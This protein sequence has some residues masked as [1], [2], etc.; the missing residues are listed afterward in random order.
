MKKLNAKTVILWILAMILCITTCAPA[1]A[2]TGDRVLLRM[3]NNEQGWSEDS[4]RMVWNSP[5]GICVMTGWDMKVMRFKDSESEP[6]TF[7][8]KWPEYSGEVVI[9]GLEGLEGLEGIEGLEGLAGIQGI[10]GLEGIEGAEGIQGPET[11]GAEG[12]DA[13]A[14]PGTV[15]LVIDDEEEEDDEEESFLFAK[16]RSEDE[17]GSTEPKDNGSVSDY[18]NTWFTWKGE[19]YG[20]TERNSFDEET[21]N[22]RVDAIVVKR[23]KLENGESSLV[24]TDLPELDKEYMVSNWGGGESLD[25][26]DKTFTSGNYLL[27]YDYYSDGKLLCFDLTDGSCKKL[28]VANN[29]TIAPGGDGYVLL[30]R[31]D[32]SEESENRYDIKISKMNPADMN[33]EPLTE[34]KGLTEY[35]ETFCYDE[36]KNT[37]Y[38]VNA[39]E[40]WAMP[41]LDQEKAQT[42]N[43][44]S[45]SNPNLILLPDGNMLIWSDRTVMIRSTDPSQRG[46]GISLRVYDNS[47]SSE[48]MN[49]AIF[50][51]SNARN[52]VSV[53]LQQD[54]N[55]R[56]DILQAMMNHDG[57]T[58]IF[59]LPYE[60]KNFR[61]LK[62]R[63]YMADLSDNAQIA[64]SVERMYP[65][66]RDA[67]KQDGKI[68]AVPTSMSSQG[69]CINMEAWKELGKTEED[70]PKTWDQFFDWLEE[71]PAQLEGKD[72][73]LISDYMDRANFRWQIIRSIIAQYQVMVDSKGT[74]DYS[75]NTPLL[76]GLL[77]RLSELDYEK[78]GVVETVDW[79]ELNQRNEWHTALLDLYSYSGFGS[80]NSEVPLA[81]KLTEE[82]DAVIP[83]T[84]YA[85]FVNP[86]S[87]HQDEAKELLAMMIRNQSI[88]TQYSMFT[89][90]TEPVR[91]PDAD[92]QIKNH[93]EYTADLKKRIEDEEMP[94]EFRA[95]M[96]ETLESEE[97]N[98]EKYKDSWLWIISQAAID[99]YLKVEPLFRVQEYDI[100]T[101]LWNS[102][103]DENEYK[104]ISA[105]LFGFTYEG[106]DGKPTVEKISIEEALKRI[107]QKV[108]MKRKEGN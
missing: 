46:D 87:E 78:I 89:D 30:C 34:V 93:E 77:K 44:C 47:Y 63:G 28:E 100:F 10:E 36:E 19:V 104:A 83:V 103:E 51:M 108:M 8:R 81:M 9:E 95:E 32:L 94:A 92:E 64:A 18:C 65:F 72:Y 73:I 84:L 45:E 75:Y 82:D 22:A 35:P 68:I 67:M 26:L 3:K 61:A 37:L 58:D 21:G 7:E 17:S 50:E 76:N 54:W 86:Y 105:A 48:L 70:L 39:G 13:Q 5:E 49:E 107:D 23:L 57:S 71:M 25:S 29:A 12:A 96:Q 69:I 16:T 42:V 14:A 27:G 31:I 56:I 106:E 74:T 33:E 1:F 98:W 6:E 4:I 59:I 2:S 101:D 85:A 90:K 99:S 43:E 62:N 102:E 79:E 15:P 88:Y 55:T 24:D 11:A 20:L 41:E 66:L 91:S 53:I 52:D 97:K 40:L 60:G 38:Y 80:Y